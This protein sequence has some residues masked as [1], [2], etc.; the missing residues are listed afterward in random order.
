MQLLLTKAA[1]ERVKDRLAP[2]ARDL[3]IVTVDAP[4]RYERGGEEIP[5]AELDPTIVWASIDSYQSG[6]LVQLFAQALQAKQIKWFQSLAAGVD[7]PAFK[8]ILERGIRL[9]KTSA[10]APAIAEYVVAHALSLL[11]PIAEQA[12]L[13][14]RKE[15]KMTPFRE[16]ADTHWT[17][18]GFGSIGRAIA[19]RIKPFG[20]SLS[21]VR[22]S[23]ASDPLADETLP[24]SK[25][26]EV[27]PKSDVVVLAAAL[28][29]ET[30]GLAGEAFFQR[31]KPGALLINIARGGLVDEDAL[32][33]GL[34][35]SQPAAA[36]LDVTQTE[37]LPADH[38]L[39]THPRVRITGHTSNLGTGTA[40][41]ADE[42]FL[43]NLRRFR[44]GEPLLNEA[45]RRE[46]GL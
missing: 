44:A 9:T 16:I 6:L 7:N 1:Y 14:V 33:R 29:D 42:Q 22:H 15:W 8:S 40:R 27:L 46:V 24:L 11:H 4:D 45:A 39:W 31:L 18:V 5:A 41:R 10:Q 2:L 28:N 23:T 43:D 12:E 30:K 13:Q 21:V 26:P 34:E 38:W 37:P 20:A 36:V 17:L 25:L 32:K 3:D 19:M 35:R